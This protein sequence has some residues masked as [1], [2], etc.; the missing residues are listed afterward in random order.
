MAFGAH[1]LDPA[2]HGVEAVGDRF[3]RVSPSDMQP[4]E[5]G[6]LDQDADLSLKRVGLPRSDRPS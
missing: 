4:R 2:A 3:L 1:R 6:K 5:I